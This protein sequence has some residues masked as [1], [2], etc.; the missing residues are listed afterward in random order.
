MTSPAEALANE[1]DAYA[2]GRGY[3]WRVDLTAGSLC[4]W[5][6]TLTVVL[7]RASAGPGP[8]DVLRAAWDDMRAWLDQLAARITGTPPNGENDGV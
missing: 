6:C 3:E 1:I 2:A 5:S 4:C 7:T 8:E